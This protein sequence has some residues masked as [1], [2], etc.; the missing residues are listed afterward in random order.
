MS[1]VTFRTEIRYLWHEL[2][3]RLR[4]RRLRRRNLTK[5]LHRW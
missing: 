4:Q 2:R 5:A 1:L 3:M